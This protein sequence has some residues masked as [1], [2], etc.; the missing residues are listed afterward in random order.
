MLDMYRETIEHPFS[1]PEPIKKHLDLTSGKDLGRLYNIV[2]KAGYRRRT[3]RLSLAKNAELVSLLADPSSWWRETAQ[4]LLI[5]RKAQ[6]AVPA[7]KTLARDRPSALGRVHA[8]WTLQ[9]LGSLGPDDLLPSL[10]DADANVREQA[11]RLCDGH[12]DEGSPLV[13]PLLSLAHD[14]DAIVRFQTALTL[15]GV[16]DRGRSLEALTTIA[17]ADLG[18]PWTRAAVLSSIPGRASRLIDRLFEKS[19]GVFARADGRHWLDD[20]TVLVGAE[21]DPEAI[22]SVLARFSGSDASL[23]RGRA[24]SRQGSPACGRIFA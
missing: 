21:N 13:E 5:E 8:L 17:L 9:A 16:E 14:R 7:L 4:R 18:D 10:R 24:R 2:P 1:I 22:K 20:L 11:A 19:P 23:T 15:G 6:D 12:L 3:P